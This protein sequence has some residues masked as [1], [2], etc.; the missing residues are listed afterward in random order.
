M[1][2]IRNFLLPILVAF[3]FTTKL[4]AGCNIQ[5][6]TGTVRIFTHAT[7]HDPKEGNYKGT[8]SGSGTIVGDYILTASHVVN[9]VTV[10]AP[11]TLDSILVTVVDNKELETPIKLSIDSSKWKCDILNDFCYVPIQSGQSLAKYKTIPFNTEVIF[12]DLPRVVTASYPG[13]WKTRS[14]G[15]GKP[16]Q[17]SLKTLLVAHEGKRPPLNVNFTNP[18]VRGQSGG[19]I[20]ACIGDKWN[21]VGVSTHYFNSS[22]G[23]IGGGTRVYKTT[24]PK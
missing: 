24:L 11:Y 10:H 19:G 12:K 16:L 21:Q 7:I 6:I 15:F 9:K 18:L 3:P 20:Y 22:I 1:K 5:S 4:F 8:G 13:Y 14:F 2:F 17:L 23:F